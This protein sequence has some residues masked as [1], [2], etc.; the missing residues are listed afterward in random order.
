MRR[1]GWTRCGA[2][3]PTPTSRGSAST[4]PESVFYYRIH[5]PV[6][7]IEFDHQT[8]VALRRPASARPT[9]HAHRRP[10]AER[11]RLRQGPAPPALREAQARVR[12]EEGRRGKEER[13]KKKET[14]VLLPS[15]SFF[16]SSYFITVSVTSI[17]VTSPLMGSTADVYWVVCPSR[18]RTVNVELKDRNAGT[19][20][21]IAPFC[22]P[23][24]GSR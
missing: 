20:V 7:L 12:K 17:F 8:P 13:R 22:A 14:F 24:R 2:P 4:A 5:S 21:A 16:L 9:P 10:H 19:S 23:S 15:S 3:R 11:Q 1:C 6:I 18:I